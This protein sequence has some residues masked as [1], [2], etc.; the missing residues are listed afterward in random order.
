MGIPASMCSFAALYRRDDANPPVFLGIYV[1]TEAIKKDFFRRR[2][3]IANVV[4]GSLYELEVPD[5]F[6]PATVSQLQ[7]EWSATANQD[8]LFA[9]DQLQNQ[10]AT[11]LQKTLDLPSF[12]TFWASEIFLKDWDGYTNSMNNTFVFDGPQQPDHHANPFRF[13]PHG[14]DQ[15]LDANTKPTL[16][17]NAAITAKLALKDN[18]LRYQLIRTLATMGGQLQTMNIPGQVDLFVPLVVRLWRGQDPFFGADRNKTLELAEHV[19]LAAQQAIVDLNTVFGSGL[20]TAP[21]DLAFRLVRPHH[22]ECVTRAAVAANVE[23]GHAACADQ[24]AQKWVFDPAPLSMAALGFPQPL[25][26]YRV[27]NQGVSGCLQ[28]DAQFT[29]GSQHF[30]LKMAPC[31]A[32]FDFAALLPGPARGPQLRTSRL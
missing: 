17:A 8:F 10:P 25:L 14:P 5:D 9:I 3:A 2:P 28:A 27:R 21:A 18:G 19:R 12:I 15:V 22:A 26:L 13:I 1:L 24:P 23:P 32:A 30:N 31:N 29:D 11:A 6:T 7:P 16:W 4:N 20:M